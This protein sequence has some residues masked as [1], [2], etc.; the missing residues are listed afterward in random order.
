[1]FL[2]SCKNEEPEGGTV[3][4]K[5]NFTSEEI[6]LSK[7]TK[8]TDS[9]YTQFG[10]YIT[11]LTPTKF[12]AHIWTIGYIDT[13]LN[14]STNDANM[15][16][17]I[18]QNGA[19]LSPTDTSRYIDFS[20]N[21]VVN[22]EPLIAGNLYNDGLFQY[23]EIDFIYFYFIPYNFIQEIHLPEEYNVDQLEMFPDEQIINNVITVNQYAMI[24][25]IFPYAK[26][27]LVIYYIFGKTD[28]TYVVNP[29]GE[30]VDLS[31]DCPIAIPEQD[32]V[33][34]SQKYNNMIFNSP[35]DGGTVVMNGTISFNT[36]DLIQVYAGVDNIPYTSDDAFV[37]APLYWERICAILEVE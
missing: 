12:T 29:N 14:F 11:S 25:K 22:F 31:D 28:S 9:L 7:N 6:N 30:Y 33:I 34:R 18:N 26:T 13:V 32:L 15:L 3:I 27:N 36:Q 23:E 1:M 21:N 4:Y 37:Y 16:Q 17:Y 5:I 24:D 19:T 20:E 10:D 35:I 2:N 8:V